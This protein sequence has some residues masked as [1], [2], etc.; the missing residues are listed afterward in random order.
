L[1]FDVWFPRDPT[2]TERRLRKHALAEQ[3]RGLINDVLMLDVEQ[4][5]DDELAKVEERLAAARE[6]FAGLADIR[7]V[8]LHLAPHDNSLFERSPLT[9]RSNALAVPLVMEFEGDQTRGHAT[10]PDYYE[11]PPGLVHGGYVIS[12]FDDLLGVA[13]AASGIAGF[14]GTLTVKLLGGT[15]LNRRIDY[16]AGVTSVNG[17]KVIAWGKSFLDGVLLAEAEGIFI[18]P[19]GGH[20]GKLLK[21]LRDATTVL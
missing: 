16:Q 3:V 10:Y 21:D 5:G 2:P 18:E 13:Q 6:S 19:R 11:G 12:A 8:G 20:P 1:S 7:A 9:G 4:V 15:P 14:T 17:R